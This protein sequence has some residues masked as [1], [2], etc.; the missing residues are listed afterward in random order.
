MTLFAIAAAPFSQSSPR[1]DEES[2]LIAHFGND[3]A[4][5][6]GNIPLF[7][8]S[9]TTLD[10]VYYYRWAV[11][12]A[13]QRDL[14]AIG[15]ITTEFLDDVG[16]QREPYASLNDASGFH[17]Y[18]GRWLRNRRYADDYID[19]L[20]ERGG[21]DR[22][23]SEAIADATYARF[24]VDGDLAGAASHL[25]VMRQTYALWDERFDFARQLY[26]IEPLLD[27]TEYTIA[28]IDASG[29][30]DGFTGG[31]AFRPSINSYMFANARAIS[32]LSALA[33]DQATAAEFAARAASLRI[34]VEASLWSPA[35]DHFIDRYK[36]DN[37][38]VHEWNPIRGRELVGYLPW[39][40]GL[41]ADEARFGAAWH[42]L[43]PSE[44]GAPF[45]LRT[46]EPSYEYYM[47]QY[48]YDKLT[49]LRECQWNGPVWPFQTTQLLLAMGNLIR[50]YRQHGVTR[51]DYLRLLRQ[52]A[53]LHFQGDRLDIEE[54]YDPATGKPIVGLARS[55]HY[56]H[57]G[58]E[59]LILGGVV[60]I[61]PR[62]DDVLEI[63]PL[64]SDDA[65]DLAPMSWFIAQDV[66]Y[67]GHLV[68]VA[69]D[70]GGKHFGGTVGLAV[71]V[72]GAL[73]AS[74][75]RLARIAIPLTRRAPVLIARPVDLAVELIR[76]QFPKPSVSNEASPK[77]V[78]DAVDGRVM[79]F[80]ESPNGWEV[81]AGTT[82]AWFAVDL[83][84]VMAVGSAE[85]AFFVDDRRFAAPASYRL[86][87]WRGG[88]WRAIPLIAGT[89]PLA[90]GVTSI[91]WPALQTSQV[92]VVLRPQS[93][94]QV[95]LVELKLF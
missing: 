15:F 32:Q 61:R 84:R 16:W 26:W 83:G 37:D 21:N 94:K 89:T 48:R 46:V 70:R 73:E 64:A 41:P 50:D 43:S 35:L 62:E 85:L 74:T 6:R 69:Y 20:Y 86:E 11:Y 90:N 8:S 93:G 72:D 36:V 49:G 23:F 17:I 51:S 65:S 13:H 68:T 76:G 4:W 79:F 52:Y 44:L 39:T 34:H 53:R 30:L 27:A 42:H 24:L 78:H 1:L 22:H 80:R 63:D 60:G 19:F 56:F 10:S 28:S 92:R 31:Q 5:Y 7:A 40:F 45:G 88:A 57:S 81:E 67:H 3:A 29:G 66:P 33:G 58:F 9:D 54:D 91:R 55:H 14:G 71:Y 75:P 12:R 25:T 18:E 77:M 59:D 82:E 87:F 2:V 47:H 95:R 38:T